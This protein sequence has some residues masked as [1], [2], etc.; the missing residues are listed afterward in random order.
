V[1]WR[2]APKT[3]NEFVAA[4]DRARAR[5]RLDAAAAAY[6]RALAEHGPDPRVHG[7]LA[8]VLLLL[9]DRAGAAASFRSA[10]EGHLESGFVDRALAVYRQARQALPL[11]PEFHSE[12]ARI[13]LL[14]GR[15]AEAAAALAQGGR[16]LA[17]R[18][19]AAATELLRGA[20]ALQPS[21]LEVVVALAP[22]LRRQGGSA[23][24]L[25]LLAPL[26]REARGPELRRVRWAIF[27]VAPGLRT[28]WRW[29]AACAA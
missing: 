2:R 13:H 23:E 8:P 6:R 9:H 1:L 20:L 3:R 26:E 24:A 7:K 4:G 11:E 19:P 25:A 14:R 27:R 18:D 5:G 15:R 12:A 28:G 22:L 29:L 21:N 16:A 10:A 17:R